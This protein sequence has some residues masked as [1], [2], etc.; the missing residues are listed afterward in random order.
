M[1]TSLEFTLI[2]SHR[3]ISSI[4]YKQVFSLSHSEINTFV[5]RFFGERSL[6]LRKG[7][8]NITKQKNI[9]KPR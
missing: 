9:T 4:V 5:V 2:L 6:A 3:P 7:S 1:F 8:K